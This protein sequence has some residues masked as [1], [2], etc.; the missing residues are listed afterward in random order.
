MIK[1]TIPTILVAVV[2]VAGMFAFMP[3]DKAATVH[4]TILANT[5]EVN[6][7]L[8]SDVLDADTFDLEIT[9]GG[10]DFCILS[11]ILSSQDADIANGDDI[12][13]LGIEI[14]DNEFL[15][16]L[17]ASAADIPIYIPD[18]ADEMNFD[19]WSHIAGEALDVGVDWPGYSTGGM[20]ADD[21]DVIDINFDVVAGSYTDITVT[22][23]MNVIS[24]SENVP[25]LNWEITPD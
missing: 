20:C 15:D 13:I 24:A 21:N 2:L 11:L 16:D 14:N 9:G 19:L 3:V 22:A 12:S 23:T 4:T 18:G 6:A 8:E 5:A 25:T 10:S 7:V 1:Y 17:G